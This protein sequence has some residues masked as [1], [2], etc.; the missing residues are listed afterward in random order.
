MSLLYA[1]VSPAFQR[2]ISS[3]K[4]DIPSTILAST[5]EAN[6]PYNSLELCVNVYTLWFDLPLNVK[7]LRQRL[8]VIDSRIRNITGHIGMSLFKIGTNLVGGVISPIARL[9][10]KSGSLTQTTYISNIVGP[11]SYFTIFGGDAVTSMYVY[12]PVS[13]EEVVTIV[14]YTYGGEI[15]LALVT[16]DRVIKKLPRFFDDFVAGINDE[17][18]KYVDLSKTK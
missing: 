16:P 3:S 10:E 14:A 1:F 9:L 18:N 15:T 8:R 4:L 11:Q 2:A 5:V 17:I 13:I 6:Y 12:S 7:S